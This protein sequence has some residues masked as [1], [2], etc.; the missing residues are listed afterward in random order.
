MIYFNEAVETIC[1]NGKMPNNLSRSIDRA[2]IVADMKKKSIIK[3]MLAFLTLNYID[4][5]SK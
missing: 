3:V 4:Y 1:I 2:H 5:L